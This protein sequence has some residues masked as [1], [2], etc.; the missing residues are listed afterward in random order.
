MRF[1][2][3]LVRDAGRISDVQRSRGLELDR[4][5]LAQRLRNRTAI[6]VP[7]LANSLD[8]TVQL[9]E[10]MESRAFGSGCRR[11]FYKNIKISRR[12]MIIILFSFLPL[13]WGVLFKCLGH[14]SYSYFPTLEIP[15]LKG[16]AAISAGI[17]FTSAILPV[18]LAGW[19]KRLTFD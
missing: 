12:D 8:R 13:V 18:L 16:L 7:L 9:A 11:T 1:I 19:K 14:G 2:P 10:A 4:G 5:N 6:L 17:I 15:E 3:T